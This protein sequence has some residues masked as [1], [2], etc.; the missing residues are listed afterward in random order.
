M[1]SYC[2]SASSTVWFCAKNW[3]AVQG[4]VKISV[5]RYNNHLDPALCRDNWTIE[6][7]KILFDLH[8]KMGNK[9]AIISQSLGPGR[10]LI[11]T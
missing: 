7:E 11:L 10:Y 6:E 4:K 9:W 3:K 8:D 1:E 2:D 5:Y